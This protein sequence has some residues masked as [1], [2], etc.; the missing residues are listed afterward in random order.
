MNFSKFI[1]LLL[2]VFI[3]CGKTGSGNSDPYYFTLKNWGLTNSQFKSHIDAPD[4]WKIEEG[5]SQVIVAVID[6]G[7]DYYH[8]DLKSNLW[9]DPKN[10]NQ[11]GW[12]FVSDTSNPHDDHGHG[13]HIAGIIGAI[14]DPLMG[15]SG[16]A[17]HVSIMSV[18]YYSDGNPGS[19]NLSNTVK[20]IDYAVEHGAKIINYSGGGPDFSESEYV[21]IKRA[22]AA[23]VLFVA[24]AGNEHQDSD[25]IQNYYYPADYIVSNIISVA[26]TDIENHLLKSS[27]WGKKNVEVAAPG[28]NIYSTLP[29]GGF[30]YMSGTSQA[31]AFVTGLAALLLSKNPKLTPLQLKEIIIKSVDKIPE[32]ADKVASGGRINAYSALLMLQ[33]KCVAN[34]TRSCQYR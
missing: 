14:M 3:T 18:K 34:K 17:H 1:L 5:S 31:T 26:A 12:N 16:V 30:G 22:E 4:A 29:G 8:P 15:A 28:E 13:T 21:A 24:A 2:L 7:I 20:A 25:L 9:H 33:K 10:P 6:T 27:N 23:G 19:V 32:L 11:F